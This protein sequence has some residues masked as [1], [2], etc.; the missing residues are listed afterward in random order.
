MDKKYVINTNNFLGTKTVFTSV[1]S[2]VFIG[3]RYGL[4]VPGIES[5]G[6]GGGVSFSAPVQNGHG[7]HP[8]SY[9]MAIGAFPSV[10]PPGCGVDHPPPIWR[11]G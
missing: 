5:R 2:A 7:A 6:G 1:N 3:T 8:V 11:R 9:T 4:E 10:Q